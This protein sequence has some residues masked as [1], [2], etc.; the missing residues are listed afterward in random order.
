MN[1]TILTIF[2]GQ[3]NALADHW[4]E[5]HP[6]SGVR[7][8]I[9]DIRDMVKGSFRAVDD[10]PYGGG[11][12]MILRVEPVFRALETLGILSPEGE[13][14]A[15]LDRVRVAALS[16]AGKVFH[17]QDARRLS[18][19]DHL[20]LICGHYEGMDHWRPFP[21]RK[22]SMRPAG[23]SPGMSEDQSSISM[24]TARQGAPSQPPR[25]MGAAFRI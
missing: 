17:Q 24:S 2:P 22:A 6:G 5:R 9:L 23:S 3:L 1:I 11:A 13:R 20:V 25:L 19:L 8:R 4:D 10:S 21:W 12:G 16:P 18:V 15:D 7:L 14:L